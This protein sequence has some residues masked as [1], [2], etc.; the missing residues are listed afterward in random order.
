MKYVHQTRENECPICKR[1]FYYNYNLKMHMQ[2]HT[3]EKT[4]ICQFCGKFFTPA[5]LHKHL[6][7]HSDQENPVHNKDQAAKYQRYY[8]HI[9][10]PAKRF[11][12][13]S[14]LTEHRRL[15]HNDFECPICRGWFSCTEAL[16]NHLKTHSSKERKHA[17]TVSQ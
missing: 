15:L 16:Q 2:I 7:I 13:C 17:C 12:L 9:C 8:C 4:A 11:N 1:Q 10:V 14:E 6:K 3:N 5:A